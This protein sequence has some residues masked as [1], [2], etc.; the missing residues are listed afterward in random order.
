MQTP[1]QHYT[2]LGDHSSLVCGRGLDS[3]PQATIIWTSPDGMIVDNA[4]YNLEN[5]SDI[6]RLNFSRTTLND[7]GVW[8]CELVVRSERHVVTNG[9][10]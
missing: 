6:V 5:G 10:H 1:T 8:I 9:E 4:R 7:S 2:L 3:N